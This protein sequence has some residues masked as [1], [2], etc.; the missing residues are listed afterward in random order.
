MF[1]LYH[2]NCP[3]HI[4]LFVTTTTS[5]EYVYTPRWSNADVIRSCLPVL[6]ILGPYELVMLVCVHCSH[7]FLSPVDV[8]QHDQGSR[9]GFERDPRVGSHRYL[10][11][12]YVCEGQTT[13]CPYLSPEQS[14][15]CRLYMGWKHTTSS[16]KS[17]VP[18]AEP[19]GEQES[20]NAQ[21]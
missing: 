4:P 15:E 11:V 14:V 7:L 3:R 1:N 16:D 5:H 20:D 8:P 17:S 10:L 6:T 19:K 13:Q 9:L 12:C 21:H 18:T 2:V